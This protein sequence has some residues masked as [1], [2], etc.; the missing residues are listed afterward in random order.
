M[1]VTSQSLLDEVNKAIA[2]ILAGR[3]SQKSVTIGQGT[4]SAMTLDLDGLRRYRKE[5][6]TEVQEDNSGGF[7][8]RAIFGVSRS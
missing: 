3:V 6:M 4:T 8:E 7:C 5:L 1:S 2:E